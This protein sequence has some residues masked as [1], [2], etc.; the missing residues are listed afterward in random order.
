M[1]VGIISFAHMHAHGYADALVQLEGVEFAGIADDNAERGK[2]AA[3]KYGTVYYG[4]V[5][6]LLQAVDAVVV[7]SENIKHHQHVVAAAQAGKHILC[8]KPLSTTVD[9]AEDMIRVCKE[10]GVILQTAFPVRFNASVVRAKQM[11][12]EGVVGRILAIKGTNRGTNPGGWFV[13]KELSG[14]GAMIDH[15]VHVVDIMRWYMNAEVR[16]VY[17]EN[18]TKFSDYGIDDCGIMSMEFDNGVFA[19]LDFSWS[20]N[21]TFPT[22]GDVTLEI[23]GTAGTLTVDATAQR[24]HLY[25]DEQGYKYEGWG[26]DMDLLLVRDFTDSVRDGKEP[27]I[28]GLDG[29]RA[30]EVALNGY[31]SVDRG[32]TVR[33]R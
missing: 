13:Q 8:E 31:Q 15:T 6:E 23:V 25:S 21:K 24:L 26:E 18:D 30:V 1:R 9:K 27:S 16:E 33:I 7:T 5:T 28:T 32:E 14:G 3:E 4:S 17:A 20:R 11:I 29:L 2:Q 10:N 19:S 22:W 12:D